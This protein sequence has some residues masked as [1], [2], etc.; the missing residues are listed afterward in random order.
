MEKGESEKE[1][2]EPLPEWPSLC[3]NRRQRFG[4]YESD[5]LPVDD[6]WLLEDYYYEVPAFP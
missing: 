4:Y 6:D 3:C 2:S 1:E 5:R